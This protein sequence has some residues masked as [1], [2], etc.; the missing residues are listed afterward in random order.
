MSGTIRVKVETQQTS[1][2]Q[3][4]SDS[5]GSV[6]GGHEGSRD[7]RPVAADRS[8]DTERVLV[9]V[10][11]AASAL[12][13]AAVHTHPT[14]TG[15]S[16][17][18]VALLFGGFVAVAA[19]RARPW[20]L[21]VA[22]GVAA[23]VSSGPWVV[24]GCIAL[25]A[26]LIDATVIDLPHRR[27]LGAVIGAVDVQV[28]LRMPTG[29]LATNA[30]AVAIAV[31]CVVYSGREVALPRIRRRS[32]RVWLVAGTLV[33]LA[34]VSLFLSALH[35]RHSVDVG[36]ARAQRGLRAARAGN[37]AEA[38][39]L[40][41]EA[42]DAFRSAHRDVGGWWTKPSLVLPGVGQ[43]AQA[44]DLLSQ[45]GADVAEAGSVAARSAD[46]Q[47]LRVRDGRLDL[48]RVRA[49]ADPLA[50]V[51]SALDTAGD[52]SSRAASPWLLPVVAHQ[53]D[54]FTEAVDDATFDA[55]TAS[56]AVA[57]LPDLLG[58][59]GDRQYFVVF[60]TPSEAR[61]LGGFMGAYGLLT[62]KDGKLSLSKTGRVRDLNRAGK[63]RALTD[64]SRFPDRFLTLAPNLYWQDVTGTSDFPTVAEAVRQMWPQSGGKQLDGV[65]YLDPE[66][67]AGMMRLTGPVTVAGYDQPLT[68]DTA[69]SFL[70]RDQYALFPNDSR[71][72]FLVDAAKTVFK[73]L[74]TGTLPQPK[75]IADTLAPAVA[76]RR[77]ML[78]SFHPDEQALFE[79]LGIDGALPPVDGDFLSVRASNRGLSKIDAYMRR[80]VSDDVTVDPRRNLVHSTVTVTVHNDAPASGL[81]SIVIG[82]HRGKP[83]GTNSTTIAVSTPLKLVDVQRGGVSIARGASMEYGRSVFT[84]LVD[85]PPGAETTVTFDLE[86]TIDVHDG[87]RLEVLPQPLVNPDHLEVHVHAAPGWTVDSGG[88][89]AG[90]LRESEI[91]RA[92]FSR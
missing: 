67:L 8:P 77:L 55:G 44:L 61:D 50:S 20:A 1:S 91:V 10:V 48:D 65:V 73:K 11:A 7:D 53:L 39:R 43:Q 2:E 89:H 6:A 40:L 12:G 52:A 49:M 29:R 9:G 75:K 27:V 62:A 3:A 57:V 87:Y 14:G 18:L 38:A 19:S 24:V 22:S 74:T 82:N 23:A 51:T 17:V 37:S 72:E 84:A 46:V 69:A 58:G 32:R 31:G 15:V 21:A 25:A 66:A 30:I 64:P 70:L 13:A 41:G 16:D 78:N 33:A 71:H 59:N 79:R 28:L 83:P 4:R 90:D 26:C 88:T 63:G 54:Q 34:V 81:P 85:V 42:S 45:A 60:A 76:E 47:S 86:G 92:S 36:I 80:T 35:A 68:P 56:E 5:A